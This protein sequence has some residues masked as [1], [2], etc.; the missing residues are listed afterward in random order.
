MKTEL[1]A[2]L[3]ELSVLFMKYYVNFVILKVN[4]E[5]KFSKLAFFISF[6]N[7]FLNQPT[8]YFSSPSSSSF[9]FH[10]N[11]HLIYIMLSVFLLFGFFF[12]DL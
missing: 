8:H 1:I 10:W 2:D 9:S 5:N 4:L 3:R 11:E 6:F 7:S 12:S